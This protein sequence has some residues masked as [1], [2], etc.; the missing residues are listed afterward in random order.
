MPILHVQITGQNKAPDGS[1]IPIDSSV[2]FVQRGPVVQ[3]SVSVAQ[4]IAQPLLQKGLSLP[5]PISGI[6][7]IDTGATTTCID[8]EAARQLKLPVVNVATVASASHSS[9][10]HNV[11]PIQI[12]IAGLPINY[13]R[14]WRD[15]STA[16]CSGSSPLDWPRC[17][18]TPRAFL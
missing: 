9:T 10:Q 3:A 6:A 1:L 4:Q 2:A 14:S 18:S 11:Y 5:A 8:E 12:S 17:S 13:K 16:C 15:R 7:L